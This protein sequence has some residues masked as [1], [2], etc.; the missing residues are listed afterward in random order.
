[1]SVI[2]PLESDVEQRVRASFARQGLL[3]TLNGRITFIGPGELHIEA[4]FDERF[5][6][7]DGFLH[8]GVVTMLMDSACGYASYTLMPTGS[9]VLT[10][11]FK[12]NFLNPGHHDACHDDLR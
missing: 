12:V 8:A 9:C 1:M 5:T 10:V 11:E 6:Q 7:Q 2:S 4:P 3:N